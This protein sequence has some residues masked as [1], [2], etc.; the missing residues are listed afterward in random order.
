MGALHV[1]TESFELEVLK[2][3]VPVVVDFWA[4]WCSPCKMVSPIIDEISEELEGKIKVVKV[5]IDEAQEIAASFNIMSIPN[6]IIF[7]KGEMVEQLVGAM[8]KEQLLEK[9]QE[10]V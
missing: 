7:K 2:S 4:E 1:T 8:S 10:K 5:N 9:I 3:D 6:I